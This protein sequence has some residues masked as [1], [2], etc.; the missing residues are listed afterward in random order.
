MLV[1]G[2]WHMAR[3]VRTVATV[4][5]GVGSFI[6]TGAFRGMRVQGVPTA[7]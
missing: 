3:L 6:D 5:L 4:W 1:A 2:A 7:P